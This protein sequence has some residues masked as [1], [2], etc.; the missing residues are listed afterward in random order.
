MLSKFLSNGCEQ[1]QVIIRN[2]ALGQES[3][4]IY[5]YVA[6]T[7]FGRII[8]SLKQAGPFLLISMVLML[9][10][11]EGIFHAFFLMLFGGVRD[12]V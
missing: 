4:G 1:K 3:S 5:C 2:D 7:L 12:F 9:I 11:G 6:H 8:F 10:P